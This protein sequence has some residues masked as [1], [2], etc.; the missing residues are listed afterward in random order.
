MAMEA[1]MKA[2]VVA[3]G[4]SLRRFQ[5]TA[6]KTAS[7]MAIPVSKNLAR[8]TT[9]ISIAHLGLSEKLFC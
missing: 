8:T 5:L 1:M 6:A 4:A 2:K 7:R 3:S 9:S